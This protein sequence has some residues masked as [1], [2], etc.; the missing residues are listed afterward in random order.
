MYSTVD[1]HCHSTASDGTLTPSELIAVAHTQGV[2]MLALT[3]H[4]TT[5]G[6]EEAVAAGAAVGLDVVPAIELSARHRGKDL[7]VVGL[8]IEPQH[9]ALHARIEQLSA[10]RRARAEHIGARLAKCGVPDAYA[11]AQTLAG[12]A[13][14]TRTH[15]ARVL[16]ERG[17]VSGMN[18]AFKRYLGA[19]KPAHVAVEWPSLEDTVGCIHAAGG[20]AV[21]AHPLAYGWTGAW[22]RRMIEGLLEFGGRGIEVISGRMAPHEVAKAADCARRYGLLASLGSDFHSPDTPWI[23]LGRVPSL[24]EDLTPVWHAWDA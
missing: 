14:V 2:R 8:N 5:A 20:V 17:H 3:D 21:M 19:G 7:H 12:E 11:Q 13:E 24:P 6:V 15:F 23:Q 22:L 18:A 9:P 10:L 1:L 16:L 4:D